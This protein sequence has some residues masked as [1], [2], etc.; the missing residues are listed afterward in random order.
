MLQVRSL[1]REV[2]EGQDLLEHK[3]FEMS[4]LQQEVESLRHRLNEKSK[5]L[6]AR[7]EVRT[8]L[9]FEPRAV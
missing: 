7:K 6:A 3:Q 8:P 4:Q 1:Q 5:D 9:V 2:M